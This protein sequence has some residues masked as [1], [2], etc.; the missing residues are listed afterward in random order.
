MKRKTSDES[1]RLTGTE[2]MKG[3]EPNRGR[4]KERKTKQKDIVTERKKEIK[5]E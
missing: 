2:R 4:K 5:K 1:E 3:E